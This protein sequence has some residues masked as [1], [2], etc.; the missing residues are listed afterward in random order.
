MTRNTSLACSTRAIVMYYFSLI[1]S[2]LVNYNM[3][4]KNR[5]IWMK[6]SLNGVTYYIT[7]Y[8]MTALLII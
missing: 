5:Q 7:N 2:K 8:F 6:W 4:L 3:T 1:I